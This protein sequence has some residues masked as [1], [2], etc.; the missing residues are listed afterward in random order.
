MSATNT[1]GARAYQSELRE[2]MARETRRRVLTAATELFTELG[3]VATTIEAIAEKAGVSRRTVFNAFESKAG[4]LL[5]IF[6]ARVR[7][8]DEPGPNWMRQRIKV[9]REMDD[10][11]AMVAFVAKA[12]ADMATRTREVWAV[13]QEAA[14]ADPEVAALLHAEEE[15]R[16]RAIVLVDILFER[17]MLRT[18]LPKA[19]LRRGMWLLSGP[20]M[21][22]TALNAGLTTDLYCT[23][24]TECL[25]G[26]LLPPSATGTSGP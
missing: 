1:G 23:W 14:R 16:Y 4:L 5:E 6:L 2:A 17:G 15:K 24:L 20:S 3:Y 21:A 25:A 9:V 18:D 12:S 11:R 7:R 22:F 13:A 8:D 19:L 10:A 26:L